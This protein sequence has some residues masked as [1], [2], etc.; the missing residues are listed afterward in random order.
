M[1]AAACR[2]GAGSA[3]ARH[4]SRRTAVGGNHDTRLVFLLAYPSKQARED[5]WKKFMADPEW[6]AAQKASEANGSLVARV[7][8]YF[9]NATDYSPRIKPGSAKAGAPPPPGAGGATFRE[10]W[11]LAGDAKFT[12]Q[13]DRGWRGAWDGAARGREVSVTGGCGGAGGRPR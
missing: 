4:G 3:A 9:L 11:L 12:S 1:R 13:G 5:S 10:G 2:S 6:Q 7:E 8:N